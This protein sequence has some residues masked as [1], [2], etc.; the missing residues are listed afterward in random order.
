VTD[1]SI[2]KPK[3]TS[4]D[5][6]LDVNM[7]HI[8]HCIEQLRKEIGLRQKTQ[9]RALKLL[10][11][12]LYKKQDI[13]IMVPRSKTALAIKKFNPLEVGYRPF[14]GALDALDKYGWIEQIIGITG[15][16]MTTI[17]TTP[18]L[19]QWFDDAGWSDEKIDVKVSQYITLRENQKLGGRSVYIDYEETEYSRWLQGELEKYNEL[20]NKSQIILKGVDGKADESFE[21]L[22]LHRRF[23]RHKINNVKNGE[24]IFG[25]RM[26]GPWA[27]LS[28]EERKRIY[29]NGEPTIDLDREASHLN[30][31]YQVVTGAPYSGKKPY[32]VEIN[33]LVIPRHIVKKF[34]SFMQN[35]KTPGGTANSVIRDYKKESDSTEYEE[36][37]DIKKKVKPSD[38]V[39]AILDKHPKIAPYYLRGKKY[40][41]YISCWESD[42]VFEVVVELTRRGIPCLTIYD[43][44]I[45]PLQY[46]ELVD[47]MKDKTPYVN[48]RRLDKVAL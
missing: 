42:I 17:K 27:N 46:K 24:F 34:S 40:G 29:I 21:N 22:S 6:F 47:E 18:K 45:V 31:M 38:I 30:A 39:N 1:V 33:G 32:K 11:C 37:L 41:D 44:F 3:L 25:G 7:P 36:Y 19:L 13:E 10:L 12:N 8:D 16:T 26:W 5:L 2:N 9:I 23:V 20:L 14:I 48:R 28:S 43:S 4:F 35:G 15:E